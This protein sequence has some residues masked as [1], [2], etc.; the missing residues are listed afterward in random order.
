MA[1]TEFTLNG[2]KVSASSKDDTPL[3]WVIREEFALSGTKFGCGQG[4]CGACTMSM[5]G[6]PIRTCITPVSA[7]K[8]TAIRTIE[9]LS[10]DDKLHPLQEQ[11]ITQNVPQCGYCQPGQIMNALALYENNPTADD[12]TIK[13]HMHGNICR[14]GTY[15]R[16]LKAIKTALAEKRE[17]K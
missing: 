1:K 7:V 14:C 3:L 11:W 2:K 10:Q 17:T 9:H 8:G 6:V 4:L 15:P 12:E 13:A 5:D 16:I